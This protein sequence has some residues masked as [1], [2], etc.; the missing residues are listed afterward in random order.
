MSIHDDSPTGARLRKWIYEKYGSLK[1]AA[2]GW[3]ISPTSINPVLRSKAKLGSEWIQRIVEGG[4]DYEY[5][6]TGRRSDSEADTFNSSALCPVCALRSAA[7]SAALR[8]FNS[9]RFFRITRMKKNS[10]FETFFQKT[11]KIFGGY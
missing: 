11:K 8:V 1:K 9:V 3:G 4:G 2:E 7:L 10:Q 6:L 5:I